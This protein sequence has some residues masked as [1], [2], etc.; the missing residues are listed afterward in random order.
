MDSSKTIV[1]YFDLFRLGAFE[2]VWLGITLAIAV[3]M[4]SN[5]STVLWISKL[6]RVMLYR[7]RLFVGSVV[8]GFTIF[9]VITAL[10][11]LDQFPNSSDE[12]V[13]LYQAENL[14][15]GKLWE[16]AP[17]VERAFGFNHIAIK[18]GIAVGRFPPGWPLLLGFFIK[19]GIPAALANPMLAILTLIFF[20]R[21]AS[22]LYGARVAGW[23]LLAMTFSGFFIFNA[24]S[25]FSHTACLLET[26][27]FIYCVYLYL[28]DY[29]IKYAIIAGLVAGLMVITR[30]YTAILLFFPFCILLWYRHGWRA[31]KLFVMISIS[32]L[33]CIL[34]FL[35]YN[36]T[37]TGNALEPVT[38]WAFK[39]EALGFVKGHSFLKGVEHILRRFSMFIYWCSP[40]IL[41]LYFFFLWDK[42]RNKRTRLLLAED[43]FFLMLMIGYF[44][45]YEIGGNQYGPRFYYEAFPFLMLFVVYKLF[46][47]NLYWATMIFYASVFVMIIKLPFIAYR[48]HLIVQE[49][50]DVFHLAEEQNLKNA[51]VLIASPT[52]VIRPMPKGDLTRN[53]KAYRNNVLFVLDEEESNAAMMKYYKDRVFFKYVRARDKAKGKLVRVR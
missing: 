7:Q 15:V 42:I 36:Y 52:S 45:Y 13:Y 6:E 12:Y 35:W 26:M 49:R 2:L 38:V 11:V 33:P 53:D 47:N 37:I 20:H 3:W 8:I 30:Y 48:E 10:L 34:F 43:Y 1:Y 39:D 17:P 21:F 14:S 16:T 31:F 50:Q 46:S 28:D 32:A 27:L 29:K 4:H 40:V 22:K 23:S 51:V 5:N 19:L 18:N 41:F 25:F 9:A 24:A 44:F